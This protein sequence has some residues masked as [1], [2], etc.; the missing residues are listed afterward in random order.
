L[1]KYDNETIIN[2]GKAIFY[3]TIY[4]D[5][6]RVAKECGWA[7]ALHGSLNNDMD[8]MAMPWVEGAEPVEEL[9]KGISDLFV[10]N[11]FHHMNGEPYKNKP[12]GRV[13]Y[14]IHIFK[15]FY[16]DINIIQR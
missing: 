12:N 10:D 11:P 14:T 13:V 8:I 1:G 4:E 3:A 16:L 7:V 5:L 9:I 2:Y 15:D 6:K